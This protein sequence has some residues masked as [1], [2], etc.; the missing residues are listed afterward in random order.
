MNTQ[1][2]TA[3]S[4]SNSWC[5]MMNYSDKPNEYVRVG[6]GLAAIGERLELGHERG[7]MGMSSFSASCHLLVN[8]TRSAQER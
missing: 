3:A 8:T 1:S 4:S 5:A 6:A 2:R 7:I